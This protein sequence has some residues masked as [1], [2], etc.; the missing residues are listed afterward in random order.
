MTHQIKEIILRRFAF[1]VLFFFQK[2]T[3]MHLRPQKQV[4]G[5]FFDILHRSDQLDNHMFFLA[6]LHSI[7]PIWLGIVCNSED[8]FSLCQIYNL[9]R[10]GHKYRTKHRTKRI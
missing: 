3:Q 8:L 5:T 4:W 10:I 6:K 9:N 2:P 7:L 1:F